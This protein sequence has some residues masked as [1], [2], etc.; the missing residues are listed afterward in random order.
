MS[1]GL[2]PA[3]R[4]KLQRQ[5]DRALGWTEVTVKVAADQVEAVRAFAATLPDPV[6][7]RDPNQLDLVEHIESQLRGEADPKEDA[8]QGGL[9]FGSR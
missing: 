4:K 5:R 6:P 3:V 9:D 7:P 2:T 1:H 8:P